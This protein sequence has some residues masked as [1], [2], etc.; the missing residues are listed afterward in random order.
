MPFEGVGRTRTVL[1]LAPGSR[2][3]A[4]EDG[5]LHACGVDII[6]GVSLGPVRLGERRTEHLR[7]I[8]EPSSV[9]SRSPAARPCSEYR[10]LGLFLY[11]DE[12]DQLEFAES[13]VV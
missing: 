1:A 6:P 2:H 12:D 8:G 9:F 4:L 5:L 10:D 11:Y 3:R 13:F 7:R